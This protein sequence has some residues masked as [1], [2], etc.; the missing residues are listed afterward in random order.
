MSSLA[1]SGR[2]AVAG[3][4]RSAND[5]AAGGPG[6]LA[7]TGQPQGTGRFGETLPIRPTNPILPILTLIPALTTGE[8]RL[9]IHRNRPGEHGPR[10]RMANRGTLPAR[11]KRNLFVRLL[12]SGEIETMT[13]STKLI[14]LI[15][16]AV[17]A[18]GAGLAQAQ[19]A[20]EWG[21][22]LPPELGFPGASA[23]AL[24]A[25][26]MQPSTGEENLP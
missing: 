11:P 3:G 25:G 15:M 6:K 26:T 10:L 8:G 22:E 17:L 2:A 12:P 16:T 7:R 23:G 21:E 9:T 18:A 13:N 19:P 20:S 24:P 14:G 5:I 4:G 1:P